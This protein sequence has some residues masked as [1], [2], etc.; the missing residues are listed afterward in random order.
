MSVD[1]DDVLGLAEL[2]KGRGHHDEASLAAY[3][4]KRRLRRREER[5][6]RRQ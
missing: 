5:R 1:Q 4:R 6:E 2:V 3:S